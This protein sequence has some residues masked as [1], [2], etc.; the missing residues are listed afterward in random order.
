[1]VDRPWV[2]GDPIRRDGDILNSGW[3][4]DHGVFST[5]CGGVRP[6]EAPRGCV[7]LHLDTAYLVSGRG[8][9]NGPSRGGGVRIFM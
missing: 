8:G 6:S 5:G 2:Y 3:P 7:R 1:M 9:D 4:A